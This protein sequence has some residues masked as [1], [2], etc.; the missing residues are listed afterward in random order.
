ME[1]LASNNNKLIGLGLVLALCV[2]IWW[3]GFSKPT[4]AAP[5]PKASDLPTPKG[6][7]S[8]TPTTSSAGSVREAKPKWIEAVIKEKDWES[9]LDKICQGK[10][11]FGTNI[12]ASEII[13]KTIVD[14]AKGGW[15]IKLDEMSLYS[16]DVVKNSDMNTRVQALVFLTDYQ[17]EEGNWKIKETLA[18][19][20]VLIPK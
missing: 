7:D 20:A 17:D 6:G 8:T 4:T 13:K 18:E 15:T 16:S 10:D 3:F 1:Q 14:I 2:G 11:R 19:N 9:A 12:K 5:L